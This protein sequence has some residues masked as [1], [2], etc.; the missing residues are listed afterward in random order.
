MMMNQENKHSPAFAAKIDNAADQGA[1]LAQSYPLSL[2]QQRFWFSEQL[3]NVNGAGQWLVGWRLRGALDALALRRALEALSRRHEILR[4][5]VSVLN[6]VP[7][8]RA[9]PAGAGFH[10]AEHDVRGHADPERESRRLIA[11]DAALPMSLEQGPLVRGLLIREKA[12]QYALALRVHK[13]VADAESLQALLAELAQWYGAADGEAGRQQAA[14]AGYG[15]YALWQRSADAHR[16]HESYWRQTLADAPV[17]LE[18]PIDGERPARRDFAAG[19][20]ERRLDAGL[21]ARLRALAASHGESLSTALLAAWSILLARLSGQAD[22]VIGLPV[23]L[24]G[25]A[26]AVGCFEDVQV[27]RL[28]CAGTSQA[29]DVLRQAA[30]QRA[31]AR[32]HAMPFEKVLELVKP[33]RSSAHSP[34]FQVMFGEMPASPALALPGLACEAMDWEAPRSAQV[35]LALFFREEDEGVLCRLDYASSLFGSESAQRALENWLVLLD[36]MSRDA[37][38]ALETLPWLSD[39]ERQL[40]LQDW[41]RTQQSYAADRCIHQLFEAQAANR[42]DALAVAQGGRRLTYAQLNEQANRLAHYLRSLGIGA[43]DRV[44]LCLDR[45]PEMLVG[46]WAVLKAGGAYVPLDPAY[47]EDRL[48][49]MLGDCSAAA[50][51]TQGSVG[52]LWDGELKR[53]LGDRPLLDLTAAA[54]AWADMPGQN[55]DPAAVGLTPSSL[56]YVIYTSGSTGQPKGVMIEHRGVVSMAASQRAA[57]AIVPDDRVLQFASFSFDACVFE[58]VMAHCHGAALYCA[59]P[60][61]IL[62]GDTLVQTIRDYGISHTLLPPAVLAGLSEQ[63]ELPSV[64]VLLAGGDALSPALVQRWGAGRH[65]INAYGPTEATVWASQHACDSQ[66]AGKPPIGRPVANARIY[67]LDPR[68]EPVPVGAVGELHIGGDGVARGYLGRPELSAERFVRDPFVAGEGRMYK[69]GDLGRWLADGTIEYLGRSDFQVKV[70]GFRIELGEI[71]SRLAAHPAVRDAVVAA[72]GE[73][74]GDKRLVAYVVAA[75]PAA[76]DASGLR[77]YLAAHL[78]EHMVP[79]AFVCL[80]ALP[81]TPN[82]K[83][84]RKALPEPSAE[85][86]ASGEYEAPQGEIETRIAEIWAGLLQV[87]RVGRNDHFFRMGGNS[88]LAVTLMERMRGS[89]LKVDV[90]TMFS[91][92]TLQALAAGASGG[93]VTAALP[94]NLIPPGCDAITPQMLPLVRLEQRDIDRIA[95]TVP[96]GAA[97]IQ[98]IYPLV[99]LQE[100]ILFHHLMSD[101]ADPYMLSRLTGF[102]SRAKLDRYLAALQAVMDRHDILRTAIAWEGLAAPVQVVW[103][104]AA[105][106]VAEVV[107]DPALEDG[108]EQMYRLVDPRH[109]RLDMRTAPLMRATI[110]HDSAQDRWL[111]LM[112]FH[113]MMCDDATLGVMRSEIQ[114][115][116]LGE[117]DQLPAPLP[118][119]N[120][121][122]EA[123]LGEVGEAQHESFFRQMLGDIDEPTAPF[124][125]LEVRGD[126][127]GIEESVQMLDPVLAGRLRDGARRHGVSAASLGHLAFA[128]VLARLTGREDVVFGTALFGRMQGAEGIDRVMG[129]FM[130]TLPVRIRVGMD[131]AATSVSRTQQLLADL[132]RH[133]HASLALAQSCSALPAQTP[134]FTALFNYRHDLSHGKTVSERDKQAWQGI[135]QL[136]GE[137]RNNYPLLV[138]I[139]DLGEGFKLKAQSQQPIDARRICDFMQTALEGLADA[140]ESHPHV[141]ARAIDVL[142]EAERA[143]ML[144]DWNATAAEYPREL[145]VHQLFEIQAGKTPDA[146]AAVQG[147][148]H[149][150]YAELNA[151]AN[152]LAHYLRGLGVRADD[153]VAVCIERGLDMLVGL[154]GVLKAGGAYVPLDPAYPTD[155]LVHM[156]KDSQPLAVLTKGGVDG[157]WTEALRGAAPDTPVLDLAAEHPAWVGQPD[158]N[159][160]PAPAGLSASSLA[161]L[162]YTSGSTGLPKGVMVEHRGVVNLLISM[163]DIIGVKA[164]DRMLSVTTFAFDI[165]ALEFYLPLICGARTILLDRS[166][167]HDPLLLGEAVLRFGAT[168]L[169]ATPSTWRMLVDGGWRGAAGLTALCGG[170]ALTGELAARL[171]ERVS[172][173]WNVYGPTETTIWSTARQVAPAGAAGRPVSESIGRPIANTSVYLLDPQGRPVPAGVAGE[174]YIGGDGVARGYL[175]RAELTAERFLPDPFAGAGRM[176]RTGD[177]ARWQEDGGIEY[178]GRN[179]FQV[180]LRGHRIE[181]G[182][183]EARLASHPGV[184]EAV[185]LARED[186]P[187]DTRLV[188]YVVPQSAAEPATAASGQAGPGFSVYFFGA[189]T[190]SDDDKYRLYL[191]SA[192]FADQHGFEA[193]WTPERHFHHVGSLYPNPAILSAALAAVT[194]RVQLRAGSVVLPL[195][196]PVRVAEEW[197]VVDNL[198]GGRVGLAIASGWHARDFVLARDNFAGR[199][200]VMQE[201]IAKLKRL[202]AGDSVQL[203]DGNGAPAEIRTFPRPRQ[204]QLP[205][206]MTAAGSEETFILAGKMGANVLTHLLGQTVEQAA[207]NIAVYR[208]TLEEH[209]HDPAAGKVTMMIHTFVSSDEDESFRRSKQPFMNYM[210]AHLGLLAPMLKSMN[211]SIESLTPQDLENIVE[212]AFERYSRS[213]ALIGTPQSCLPLLKRLQEADIDEIACLIDWMAPSDALSGLE[214]LRALRDLVELA[215]PDALALK[216]H[217]REE[218][219]EYMVP[220][221]Y[222]QLDAM[223][224]T[225]NGKLDRKALPAPDVD[226]LVVRDYEAPQGELES[227]IAEVWADLLHLDAVGRGDS[228]FE[229]GGNSLLAVQCVSRLRALLSGNVALSLLFAHP[230]L[231]DLAESLASRA[232][233]AAGLACPREAAARQS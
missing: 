111:L 117:E 9:Q 189:D 90:R 59:A 231:S 112:V 89:G 107:L 76:C 193:V 147:D 50:V 187:G 144:R 158:G 115:Y 46:I 11:A 143:R 20:V 175:N 78:P 39:A 197:S 93:T 125:L 12:T 55:P 31:A 42:P 36:G 220:S 28:D 159:L 96:G 82:G 180:K 183:I 66:R 133:E 199:K 68:G 52:H 17:L 48:A 203:L 3:G 169:Q 162:I 219:P 19:S 54:P 120:F 216:R 86:F 99:P 153:R 156:V 83:L 176:Y 164:D 224:L 227:L 95:A 174:L 182:E 24:R 135:H 33:P 40:V 121:V 171:L 198:S 13:M 150:S 14:G 195:H 105:L 190:Y 181:L 72:R 15:E 41:N 134:L 81:L 7:E 204:K 108:V 58:V 60:G 97:N 109:A 1:A 44:A 63:V 146:V 77:A 194:Q 230:V 148:Q 32:A 172:R 128:L 53:A 165:A 110:A 163:R 29:V 217:C 213:A 132:L 145:C 228:F 131:D 229:L 209:G 114:A 200:Q 214:D 127:N 226:A 23:S 202:W 27:L 141:A 94:E 116:L 70:R 142:P 201:G 21:T 98:D 225:P 196:D 38:Q 67:I 106:P 26:A 129:L 69:S 61:A 56:A 103:R 124:G 122:G 223:P 2:S 170:E 168:M 34:L 85:A 167:A 57:F 208:K 87:E 179:D 215:P 123:R 139:D 205:L 74:A 161:Y 100:G 192:K 151:R 91:S 30:A 212:Y 104:K 51:L 157:V 149:L 118:F 138:A 130:N 152:R 37:G 4:S 45:G 101:E 173:V 206:W 160:E 47:P 79:S 62:V 84:D 43:D 88:L 211:V 191:E 232:G 218:L 222:V 178:L 186:V 22:V 137:E 119:R 75:D 210:R 80:D 16:E 184:R 8:Q 207:Q 177:L 18:L 92:P 6:G 155:R 154:L 25:E 140:L 73:G 126:G 65:L 233:E 188:A 166:A 71:E 35:D 5:T 49:Y 64:R 10:L 102:D 113:H 185:V 136:Y 221:A